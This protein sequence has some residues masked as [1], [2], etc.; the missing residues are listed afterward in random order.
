MRSLK[1]GSIL[2]GSIGLLFFSA[3]SNNNNQGI[4][5]SSNSATTPAN[6]PSETTTKSNYSQG[7]KRGQ[8]V[9]SGSYHFELA[10]EKSD[11]GFHLDLFVL[12]GDNHQPIPNAK[13]TSQVQLPDGKQKSLVFT[14]DVKDKHYTALLP[15][16]ASGQYQLKVTADINGE[17]ANARFSF[18]Q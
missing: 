9:E 11:K 14:Y 5:S 18:K 16:K 4:N 2:L 1:F 3:C 13:V 8:V 7:A 15:E 12:T 17:I 6:S 10:P